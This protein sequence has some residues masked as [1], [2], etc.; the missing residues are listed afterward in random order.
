MNYIIRVKNEGPQT[1]TG[2]TTVRDTLPTGVVG[3][4]AVTGALWICTSSGADI[5]CTTTQI[6]SSGSTFTDIIVPVR[7]TAGASATVTNYAVVYNPDE[8]N[9]CKTDASMPV[10]NETDCAKDPKNI[11]P[12]QFTIPGNNSCG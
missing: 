4:G 3:S 2:T 8:L 10:G 11:D 7:I 1:T 6:V 12:A 5:S 9:P